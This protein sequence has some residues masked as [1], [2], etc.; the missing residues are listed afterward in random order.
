[1]AT[2]FGRG[3]HGVSIGPTRSMGAISFN[4]PE[5][6]ARLESRY[7][8]RNEGTTDAYEMGAR[9][10]PDPLN[11]FDV[12]FQVL[13]DVDISGVFV[14]QMTSSTT[15]SR[16][17]QLYNNGGAVSLL[18]GGNETISTTTITAGVWRFV[19]D[20]VNIEIFKNG[21]SV[22]TVVA[23][24]GASTEPNATF[25]VAARHNGTNSTYGFHYA[26]TIANVKV[27]DGSGNI[28]NS[29]PINDN[30]NDIADEV[31]GQD[32]VVINPSPDDWGLFQEVERQGN[33]Q[34][35][36]LEVPPWDSVNQILV[37]A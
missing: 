37:V 26:G 28:V 5:L 2:R 15:G 9:L 33:W 30:S 25:T 29:Y 19:F 17:F 11:H 6:I 34:G 35:S 36:N 16:E 13:G 7:F 32:G 18:L 20:G 12:E 10:I 14:A 8:R 3:L 27:R 22:E 4:L 24:V 31:G 23:N 1:M 21:A